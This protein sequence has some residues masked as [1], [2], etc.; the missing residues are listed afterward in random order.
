MLSS[1]EFS[2]AN[3]FYKWNTWNT[4]YAP[5]HTKENYTYNYE[6]DDTL[7]ICDK[8]YDIQNHGADRSDH[9]DNYVRSI[10]SIQT[11]DTSTGKSLDQNKKIRLTTNDDL[12]DENQATEIWNR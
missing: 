7:R 11:F 4:Y 3:D 1:S 9:C 2:K 5:V 10:L 6:D 12:F 8:I